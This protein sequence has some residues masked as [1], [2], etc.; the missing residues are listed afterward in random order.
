[1]FSNSRQAPVQSGLRSQFWL[2]CSFPRRSFL[3]RPLRGSFLTQWLAHQVLL[4]HIPEELVVH[5]VVILHFRLLHKGTEQPWTAI[6][7]RLL[8]IRIALF[9]FVPKQL[10]RPF[11]FLKFSSAS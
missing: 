8:Q 4:K 6:G 9:H 11:C 1:M 10:G 2:A 5:F 7:R 3:G